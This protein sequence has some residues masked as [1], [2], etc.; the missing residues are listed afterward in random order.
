MHLLGC[1]IQVHVD[2]THALYLHL[3][4]VWKVRVLS[5]QPRPGQ[6]HAYFGA[7]CSCQLGQLLE[8]IRAL[9]VSVATQSNLLAFLLCK[10][11]VR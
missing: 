5:I 1:R 2:M 4:E 7:F 6:V 11:N 8:S 9:P 10:H 3:F